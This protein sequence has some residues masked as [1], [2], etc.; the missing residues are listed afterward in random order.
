MLCVDAVWSFWPSVLLQ[1]S[2]YGVCGVYPKNWQVTGTCGPVVN[3][4]I[5]MVRSWVIGHAAAV[6]ETR[7]GS[8]TF[9]SFVYAIWRV[10]CPRC[11][12]FG[13]RMSVGLRERYAEMWPSRFAVNKWPIASRR[14]WHEI[15]TVCVGR[16][17]LISEFR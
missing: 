4:L 7:T 17:N 8:K 11:C 1:L 10:Y 2:P 14:A 13:G 3:K 5:Q 9:T 15:W 16:L 12:R 6:A